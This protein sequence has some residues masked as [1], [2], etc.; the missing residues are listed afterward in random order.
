[1]IF[2]LTLAHADYCHGRWYWPF[3]SDEDE[4]APRLSEMMEPATLLIDEASD[5]ASEGK[6]SEA[7]DKYRAALKELDRIEIEAGE[8]A[9]SPE[10]ATLR[11]KRAYVNAAIDS[12]LMSQAKSNAKTVAVS[13]T[14]E[15]ELRLAREQGRS[16]PSLV[17]SEKKP[18]RRDHRIR[19][20]LSEVEQIMNLIGEREYGKANERI[21]LI[22]KD[23]PNDVCALNLR[24]AMEAQQGL[25]ADAER[26]LDS[27]IR[28]NP[29]NYHS[30]YNMATLYL[31]SKTDARDAARRYYE[32]GRAMGGPED[33][34]IEAAL[35]K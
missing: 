6:V 25:T 15:L 23:R 21:S 35:R 8:R 2:A 31:Q 18:V 7:A 26:T 30:Y 33:T 13:D 34:E 16:L 32:T 1:M 5:L 24:A 3:G 19:R 10:F 29:R 22:L 28:S 17:K 12:M 4:K 11:T 9:K 20:T 27:A 14:S